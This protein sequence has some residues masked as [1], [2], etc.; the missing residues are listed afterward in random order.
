M[1]SVA[2]PRSRTTEI[3]LMISILEN[4]ETYWA[5]VLTKNRIKMAARVVVVIVSPVFIP[6][7]PLQVSASLSPVFGVIELLTVI[8][9]PPF[10]HQITTQLINS[11][12]NRGLQWV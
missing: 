5:K 4:D 10:I 7:T 12:I 3:S 2:S 8:G 9:L 1:R 6:L 11:T